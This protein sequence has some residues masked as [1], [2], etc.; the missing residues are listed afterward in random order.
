MVTAESATLKVGH[1]LT[2]TKSITAPRM[3]PGARKMRSMRFPIAPP[4]TS[5]KRHQHERVVGAPDRTHEEERDDDREDGEQR[6]ERL[7]E[8]ERASGVACQPEIDGVADDRDRRV[9]EL[10]DRP[11]LGEDVEGDDADH[12][13]ERETGARAPGARLL[14]RI[15]RQRYRRRSARA[16]HSTQDSAYGRASSRSSEIRRPAGTHTP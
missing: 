6:R 9:G 14:R 10:V 16:L 8:A 2:W 5:D 12:D 11:D 15:A 13:G 4:N 7:E 1:S 3:N